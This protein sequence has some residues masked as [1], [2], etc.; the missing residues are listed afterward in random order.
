VSASRSIAN[1][2]SGR[3]EQAE[4]L[5]ALQAA[6]SFD[7]KIV[8]VH[9]SLPDLRPPQANLKWAVLGALRA[10]VDSGATVAIPAFTF[11]FCKGTPYHFRSPSET[12]VLADWMIQLRDARRT[13]HPIYSFVVCGSLAATI[14]ECANSTTFGVDSTFALFEK[15][16]ATI[17]MLGSSWRNC[18]QFHCYE[19]EAQVPYRTYRSFTG[20]AD[21]GDGAEVTA[22]RMFV[23]NLEIDAENDWARLES[24]MRSEGA[25]ISVPLWGG[26]VESV[27]CR[28]IARIA[29]SQLAADPFAMVHD[30][31]SVNHACAQATSR[32]TKPPLRIALLGSAN[33]EILKVHFGSAADELI[34]DQLVEIH[35]VPF[36]QLMLEV[37]DPC[38]GLYKFD[39]DF[40][41]FCDRIEDITGVAHL[42]LCQLDTVIE[43][44]RQYAAA[45]AG[46]R[47]K[48]RGWVVINRFVTSWPSLSG[49]PLSAI[50]ELASD[51]NAVLA[52]AHAGAGNVH[53]VDLRS[54]TESGNCGSLH[55]ARLWFLGRF[56]FSDEA[57]RVLARHY[58]GL[59]LAATGRTARVLALDLDNTL[60]SGVL[61]EDGLAGLAVGGDYPGNAYA[62]FQ[63]GLKLLS[64][65]GIALALLS[66]NDED[67]AL[68]ALSELPAMVLCKDDFVARRINW[69]PKWKNIL[70]VCEELSLGL[71]NVLF[72][73]DN[74]A[75]REQMRRNQPAVKVHH[76]PEDPSLYLQSLLA[77]PW[78]ACLS[79]TAEDRRRVDGFRQRSS[80]LEAKAQRGA[81]VE[82]FYASLST[83]VHMQQFAPGNAARAQQLLQKT[84]QFNT[85]TRRYGLADIEAILAGGGEVFVIGLRDRYSEFENIGVAICRWNQP[86]RGCGL[87][88]SYLLSCRVL[89]RGIEV[90]ILQWIL[91][92]ARRRGVGSVVGEVVETP[93]NTPARSVFG[94]AGF[95]VDQE[96]PGHWVFDLHTQSEV[97]PPWLTFVDSSPAGEPGGEHAV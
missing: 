77:S 64:E 32:A 84:N 68:A 87:I 60:W 34:R 5:A 44:I 81:N 92:K 52:E 97:L 1:V 25:I 14:D 39:A 8:V 37:T 13:R 58:C 75:E 47:A 94:E 79:V 55:D 89:G 76:L 65:R 57:A 38:S 9:S 85:T 7:A 11:R 69:A 53:F 48:S 22:A 29:R 21:F 82:D 59:V 49:Q 19:E 36:G 26:V 70:E 54:V 61:G 91:A 18:T 74:P 78:L 33:L 40:T 17:V 73:D 27:A 4:I 15:L 63:R 2:L 51:G 35:T 56:P 43:R 72:I 66:K 50:E 20:T 80:L 45:I 28:E 24:A 71:E 23:R 30:V 90:G 93:R 86:R 62:A 10:L 31:P 96:H 67:L 3:Y 42:D 46:Y 41:V 6:V 12:G 88:D 95:K 83:V 16:N